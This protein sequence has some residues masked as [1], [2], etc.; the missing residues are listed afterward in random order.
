[1]VS[2]SAAQALMISSF[3]A[4]V[5]ASERLGILLTSK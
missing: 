5:R 4:L 1:M 3:R 2:Y